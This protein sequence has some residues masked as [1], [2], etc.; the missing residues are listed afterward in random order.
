MLGWLFKKV[1]SFIVFCWLCIRCSVKVFIFN[2]IVLVDCGD[3]VVFKLCKL[4]F[5]IWVKFY[6]VLLVIW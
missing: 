5:L 1:V 3:N 4:C 2:V 6:C